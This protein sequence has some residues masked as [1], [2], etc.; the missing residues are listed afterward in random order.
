MTQ[1]RAWW[2]AV[3]LAL[4]TSAAAGAQPEYANEGAKSCLDCH[5]N[6][7]VMGIVK[8][9]HAK[10]EN[11]NTPAAQKA[12]ES[13]HGPSAIHMQFPMQVENL[14]FGTKSTTDPHVQNQ[15]CLACH[16]KG[17]RKDW[18]GSAH[19]FEHV[20]CSTCHGIHD[21]AKI[22]PAK[23]TLSSGC[24]AAGCHGTLMGDAAPSS[25]SHAVGKNIGD[26]GRVTC[27]GQGTGT[28][29]RPSGGA[30]VLAP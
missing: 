15:A 9:A 27:T 25:F 3:A 7:R 6:P 13:C 16:A 21:P 10:R 18:K 5:G 2:V 8:T 12:C 14:H 1:R 26:K 20:V 24:S 29:P 17:A 19:G 22:V 23:A 11:P 30:I 4:L 28:H